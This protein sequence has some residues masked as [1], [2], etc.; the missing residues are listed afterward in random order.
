MEAD[1]RTLDAIEGLWD[2][3]T[4]LNRNEMLINF[5]QRLKVN[6]SID[7][8]EHSLTEFFEFIATSCGIDKTVEEMKTVDAHKPRLYLSFK[9]MQIFD[10]LI[11]IHTHSLLF[12]SA[13]RTAPETRKLVKKFEINDKVIELIPSAKE[14]YDKWGGEWSLYCTGTLRNMLLNEL[15]KMIDGDQFDA[16]TAQRATGLKNISDQSTIPSS[17]LDKIPEELKS[18]I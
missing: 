2:F 4:L 14:S 15:R 10:A 1:K 12:V 6:D 7:S 18:E 3:V 17:I 11:G 13:M 8:T 16:K 5:L 9:A